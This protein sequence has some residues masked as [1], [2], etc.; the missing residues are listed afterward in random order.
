MNF[1][2]EHEPVFTILRVSLEQRRIIQAESRGDDVNVSYCYSSKQ[3]PRERVC[4]V[5]LKAAV[6]GEGFFAFTILLL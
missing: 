5:L 3:K 4:S 6:G 1:K 2:I